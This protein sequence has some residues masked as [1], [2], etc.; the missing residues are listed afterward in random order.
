MS[1]VT[2]QLTR[3]RATMLS[4]ELEDRPDRRFLL[5]HQSAGQV[6]AVVLMVLRPVNEHSWSGRNVWELV[7]EI[8][9][10]L[11]E[12]SGF[13]LAMQGKCDVLAAGASNLVGCREADDL[14]RD[15]RTFADQVQSWAARTAAAREARRAHR[16]NPRITRTSGE[17][18]DPRKPR[19]SREV[20]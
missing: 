18:G 20:S 7:A 11:A 12:W 13:F 6:A 15:A 1:A 16:G 8:A 17:P 10:E 4:A 3:A 9:P 2:D 19:E 14:V 5:A